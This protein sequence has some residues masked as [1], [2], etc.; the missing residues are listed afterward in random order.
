MRCSC[1]NFL[2]FKHLRIHLITNSV[3]MMKLST[4]KMVSIDKMDCEFEEMFRSPTL[5]FSS[6]FPVVPVV[7]F[8][9][10]CP[11]ILV[12]F[13]NKQLVGEICLRSPDLVSAPEYMLRNTDQ[14]KVSF[15]LFF[16]S[17]GIT[18]NNL[19]SL[20]TKSQVYSL[21]CVWSD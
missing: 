15:V 6:V 9:V 17:M 5:T 16:F 10:A 2:A 19:M 4:S 8:F 7:A 14:V 21:F 20:R 12:S 1:F 11:P 3:S 18:V 13:A